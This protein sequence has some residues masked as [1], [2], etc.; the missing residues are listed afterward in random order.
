VIGYPDWLRIERRVEPAP[1]VSDVERGLVAR[2]LYRLLA[3]GDLPMRTVR[4]I[5]QWIYDREQYLALAMPKALR[6]AT[7]TIYSGNFEA[8][9]FEKAFLEGRTELLE[10]LDKAALDTPRP[11][12]IASNV[13]MLCGELGLSEAAFKIMGVIACYQRFDLVR[14][15]ADMLNGTMT[16]VN[17][18]IATMVSES[19]PVVE[20]LLSHHGQL[21]ANG[22]L[23]IRDEPNAWGVD[24]AAVIPARINSLLDQTFRDF[25]ELKGALLGVPLVSGNEAGDYDHVR[26]DRDLVIDVLKGA[27]REVAEGVNIL[28]YGPPGS[29]KTELTKVSAAA[30]GLTLYGIAEHSGADKEAERSERLATLVFALRVLAG[31][32]N[33][34]ILFD[35]MEDVAW[36][37]MKRGGSKAYLNRLLETNPVPVLWTSNNIREIDPALLRRMTLAVE[38]KL[39]PPAQRMRI[40][41]RLAKRLGVPLSAL[42][43][44]QL[45]RRLDATPAVLENAL[46][47]AHFSGGGAAAV[48]RA[49]RGIQRAAFGVE[50]RRPAPAIEFVPELMC[51]SRD[52]VE[53]AD[54]VVAGGRLKFSLCLSGPPGTGKSAF[55]RYLARRLG[56]DVLHKRASDLLGMFVGESEKRIA[57]AFEE[58]REAKAVLIFDEADSLLFDRRDAVR[59]WEISQVNEMLTWMEEHQLPVCFTTN[60]MDRIDAASLRRFTFH[61]RFSYLDKPALKRAWLAFFAVAAPPE[62]ALALA[63]LTPGDFAQARAQAE[64][65]AILTQPERIAALLADISRAKPGGSGAMGFMR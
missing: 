18:L 21:A 64:V 53:L 31:S 33:A 44:E 17:R 59:S 4:G 48:E 24:S 32:P 40:L 41:E 6:E 54:M 10:F 37:F 23:Q 13:A 39:P 7:A 26:D 36:Q 27:G 14:N 28:L 62:D 52:L 22:L 57:A 60:L 34:A 42:E 2:Y 61:V 3:R 1:A 51:A 56:L 58:A 38:L 35:E 5:L 16:P 15:L 46:R 50:T 30:A 19:P 20:R 11:E 9:V 45:G 8:A 25:A 29:G 55:A 47:A 65:L 12:P 63:N 49:A 43:I